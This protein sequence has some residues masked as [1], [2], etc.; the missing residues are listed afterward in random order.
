V[1]LL[2]GDEFVP[3]RELACFRGDMEGDH[4]AK[5]QP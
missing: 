2:F 4:R 5:R 1:Y 3:L